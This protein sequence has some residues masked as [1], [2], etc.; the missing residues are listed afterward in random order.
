MRVL[1][2]RAAGL[3]MLLCAGAGAGSAQWLNLRT[4]GIPRTADGKADLNAPAPKTSDGK[5]DISGMWDP[6]F[7]YIG[8]IAK[9]LKPGEL[10]FQ[11]WAAELFQH[12]RDTESK[13]DPTGSCVPGGVPRAD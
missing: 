12:R 8:N 11:P 6:G 3:M 9:D 5:P 13:E 2:W 10:S 4:P 7:A 1:R